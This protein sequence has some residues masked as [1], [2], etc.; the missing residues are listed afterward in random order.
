MATGATCYTITLT[1][2]RQICLSYGVPVAAHIPG[3]GY[4][5]TAER[6]SQTTSR[7]M[8]AFAGKEAPE[9]PDKEFRALIHPVD[10]GSTNV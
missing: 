8:N 7:H 4:V 1:D 6:Y 2:G 10:R 5:R 3:K 9:L